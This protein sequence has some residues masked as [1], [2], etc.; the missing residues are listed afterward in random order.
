MVRAKPVS[1]PAISSIKELLTALWDDPILYFRSVHPEW[2][3]KKMPWFHRGIVALVLGRTDFLL[4]FGTELWQDEEAEWTVE[5]LEKIVKYFVHFEDPEDPNS[6]KISLFQIDYTNGRVNLVRSRFMLTMLPRGFSKTTLFN[7]LILYIIG[8]KLEKYIVYISETA[9]HSEQQLQNVKNEIDNNERF[10]ELFG[11]LA[12]DRNDPEKWTGNLIQCLN[13]ITVQAIGRGGQVRGKNVHGARPG[14][15][16]LDD[17]ED[18]ES[19]ATDTQ[20]KKTLRWLMGS[21]KPALPKRQGHIFILGTMLHVESMMMSVARDPG[22]ITVRFGAM[23][24][25]GS[26]LDPKF[27]TEK[28]WLKEKESFQRQGLLAEF[29]MEYQ[30][31]IHVDAVNR[32]F[33]PENWQVQI[34]VPTDFV[35]RALA[36]DPAI[37]D[38]KESDHCAF[39]IVG[40]TPKGRLHVLDL[41][42]QIGMHPRDQVD[43]FFELKFLWN[44]TKCGVESVAYQ[45]ALVYLL[46]EEMARKS[47][48]HGS[49]AFF[50]V[51]PITHGNTGKT[52]RIEGILAPRY[53]AGYITHQRHFTRLASEAL[54]WPN[55]KKDN[56]DVVAMAVGL[57]SPLATFAAPEEVHTLP[58][59]EW[60][61]LQEDWSAQC[62]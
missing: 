39:G 56:L 58:P 9:A 2:F 51:I 45:K 11:N 1:V 62:P 52:E 3:P 48:T 18:E 24:D 19:V 26:A 6:R 32:K 38:K 54:D 7:G 33:K 27:M 15:I 44:A 14:I 41:Y 53:A 5:D 20:R 10:S 12:P 55:G 60:R 42:S 35:G 34:M 25:D 43:K 57:L 47:Q 13:G 17:V 46:T 4:N 50:E 21:V 28:E 36:M 29:Y 49:D 31:Q 8:F 61:R 59:T 22:W 16:L 40:M 37:S 23:L 30:S